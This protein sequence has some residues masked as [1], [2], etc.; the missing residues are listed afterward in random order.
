MCE[1]GGLLD[2]L[3]MKDIGRVVEV[4]EVEVKVECSFG[5]IRVGKGKSL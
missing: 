2:E 1:D 3:G 4:V 5:S